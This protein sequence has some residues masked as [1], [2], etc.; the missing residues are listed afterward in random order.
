[1]DHP[2]S[3]QAMAERRRQQAAD[4]VLHCQLSALEDHRGISRNLEAAFAFE[5]RQIWDRAIAAVRAYLP[6]E[7]P[8]LPVQAWQESWEDY[9]DRVTLYYRQIDAYRSTE[10]FM[11]ILRERRDL[12]E[13]PLG[14]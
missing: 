2:N 8:V 13:P 9:Q 3:Y 11:D 5:R 6:K 10:A 12:E 4:W 7:R 1:M 14:V